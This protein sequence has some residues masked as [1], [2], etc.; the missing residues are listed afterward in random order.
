MRLLPMEFPLWHQPQED[1]EGATRHCF[2]GDVAMRT[3]ETPKQDNPLRTVQRM[4]LQPPTSAE[5]LS[6]V[7]GGWKMPM[8]TSV[9]LPPFR[10]L[11]CLNAVQTGSLLHARF[12]STLASTK[13]R[14]RIFFWTLMCGSPLSILCVVFFGVLF[15]LLSVCLVCPPFKLAFAW[16]TDYAVFSRLF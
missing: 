2:S 8:M 5:H 13:S 10:Q 14:F 9:S 4:L 12:S 3:T 11:H 1:Q 7:L 16:S 15:V 6:L